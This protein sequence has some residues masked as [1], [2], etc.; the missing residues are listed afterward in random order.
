[1][2][3]TDFLGE[4]E[5]NLRDYRRKKGVTQTE[6]ANLIGHAR[7]YVG[8]IENG[9]RFPTISEAF[10]ICDKLDCEIHDIFV[11]TAKQGKMNN[12]QIKEAAAA[13]KRQS[14]K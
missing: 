6:L 2:E 4:V 5:N 11:R 14:V 9:L 7:Q 12:Q 1:M 8:E 10:I 3:K 13:I